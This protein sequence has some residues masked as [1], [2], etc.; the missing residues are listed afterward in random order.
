MS[1]HIVK[2]DQFS[3][4]VQDLWTKAKKRGI[5]A[6]AYEADTKTI[7]GTN[8]SDPSFSVSAVLSNLAS[9][10][11]RTSFKKDVSTDI[12][13][14]ENYLYIGTG[15]TNASSNRTCGYRHM[16]SKLFVDNFVSELIVLVDDAAQVGTSVNI[17]VWAINKQA[18]RSEDRL[19]KVIPNTSNIK[20][21]TFM[22]GSTARKCLK[23]PINDSFD[24]NEV[25]FLAK[26]PR[27]CNFNAITTVDTVYRNDA[28]NTSESPSANSQ[29]PWENVAGANVGIMYLI[30]RE[31]IKSLS[32]KISQANADSSLYVK[33]SEVSASGGADGANKVVRLDRDGK[34]NTNMLPE[35]AINRVLTADN[36]NAALSMR[37]QNANQLQLG[38]VVVITGEQNKVYMCKN[39][40]TG[41][42]FENAFIELSIG[43]GT[44]KTV[45]G[46]T[47]GTDG[48]VT[49]T[50]ENISYTG[51]I[52]GAAKSNVQEA[53][54][55]L[56]AGVNN[57]VKTINGG[58]PNNGNIQV[59]VTE[60]ETEGIKVTFGTGGTAVKI[61][62]YMTQTEVDEIKRSFT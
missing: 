60:G 61:A 39:E 44:V 47:P 57:S 28:F 35:L 7:K 49:V 16:T 59:T 11:E 20:I 4:V 58:S 3:E 27:D 50:A 32:D 31:S 40:A 22:E 30:G 12:G 51:T 17:Q 1:E 46:Q 56:D 29:L 38:D 26:L 41:I 14:T 55:A 9:V 45:N 15:R 5:T 53:I 52:G 43:N 34:L 6:L 33:Q 19:N 62:T 10:D 24:N 13:S 36:K 18:T 2:H 42:S 54:T 25:Y 21:T 8:D 48:N 37:G 23:V